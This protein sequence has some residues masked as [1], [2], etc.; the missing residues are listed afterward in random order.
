MTRDQFAN[1]LFED[2]TDE[3]IDK[4]WKALSDAMDEFG[5]DTPARMAMFLAQCAHESSYFRL[6][7][8]NLNYSADGLRKI[9]PKY[10]RDRDADDYHRQPEKIANVVYSS[11]MGNGDEESGDGW[12][13]CG[14]GFIQLTGK[15]NYD[16]CGAALGVDLHDNPD[17]LE[18][19]EGAARSAAW[20]W[21]K[22]GLNKYADS[23]DIVGATK[24]ING[25]TIGLEDRKEIY[26]EVK[27]SF[28]G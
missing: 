12:R 14:R 28:G 7:R 18:T 25:G 4:N 13:Y 3:D 9:F 15:S 1:A 10:F 23:D 6:T 2:T 17:Y 22:N 20:F 26:E 24:R 16:A 27:E 11:R 21:H 19:P 8:E 5:I